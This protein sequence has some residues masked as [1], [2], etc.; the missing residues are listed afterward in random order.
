MTVCC[1]IWSALVLIAALNVVQAASPHN[2]A[3]LIEHRNQLQQ[4]R[5]KQG[6]APLAAIVHQAERP[7]YPLAPAAAE[8]SR[9]SGCAVAAALFHAANI[10]L[11]SEPEL[12]Q[13]EIDTQ[14]ACHQAHEHVPIGNQQQRQLSTTEHD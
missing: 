10:K 5:I 4:G 3:T 11:L 9:A 13:D 8:T 6:V 12:Q 1:R 14:H 2:T 7:A